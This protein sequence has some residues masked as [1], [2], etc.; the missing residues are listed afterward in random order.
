MRLDRKL[1][2]EGVKLK[3]VAASQCDMCGELSTDGRIIF[4]ASRG[5]K[6]P[7]LAKLHICGECVLFCAEALAAQRKQSVPI[8]VIRRSSRPSR[9]KDTATSD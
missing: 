3:V 5:F 2:I 1:E 4:A 7:A 8:P 6:K 9:S